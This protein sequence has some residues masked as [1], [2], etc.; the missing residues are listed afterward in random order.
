MK[1]NH[2]DK[3]YLEYC[4]YNGWP[5]TLSH[6]Q[7]LAIIND[8]GHTLFGVKFIKSDGTVRSMTCKLHAFNKAIEANKTGRRQKPNSDKYKVK[9]FDMNASTDDGKGDFRT[10]NVRTLFELSIN[11]ETYAVKG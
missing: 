8:H 7:A 5:V 10:I 6:S 3:S 9:V 2:Y 11:G 1:N 4:K